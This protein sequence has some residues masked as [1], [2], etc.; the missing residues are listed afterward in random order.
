MKQ[1]NEL[2]S[3]S[4]DEL[5]RRLSALLSQSRRVDSDLIAH[6][7]EV[8]ERRLFA[9]EGSSSMFLYCTE[10][11]H[12]SEHEAY[13]RITAAR[14]SRKYPMLLGNI[15]E[16][17]VELSP[18]PDVPAVI[19]KLPDSSAKALPRIPVGELG[20][21]RVTSQP[22]PEPGSTKG[23]A[24]PPAPPVVE[25][26]APSRYK[27]QFTASGELRELQALMHRDLAAVIEAAVTE[28]L[29]RLEAKRYAETSI[30]LMCKQHNAYL[31]EREYGKEVMKRYRSNGDR[32]S[33]P[34][35]VYGPLELRDSPDLG[36]DSFFA[37]RGTTSETRHLS[38]VR[39]P[40]ATQPSLNA[41]ALGCQHVA[42]AGQVGVF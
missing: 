16:L 10:V 13:E 33:E 38:V 25:L 27:I 4:D 11:L 6:M 34:A 24:P 28:K 21:D 37:A 3:L 2:Q 5:L 9:R 14:A 19:R 42:R 31:A 17:L 18:K 39:P 40:A 35:P 20:P 7:A 12:L 30:S 22:T 23:P 29:D 32:V 15:E 36:A 41:P 1:T 8:D 26:L